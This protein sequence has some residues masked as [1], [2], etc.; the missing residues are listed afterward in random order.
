MA[1]IFSKIAAGE[2]PSYIFE[3]Y[4]LLYQNLF[5]SIFLFKDM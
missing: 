1:S 5:I 3:Y 2:I 4:M